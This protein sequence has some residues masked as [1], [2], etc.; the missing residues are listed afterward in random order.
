MSKRLVVP[1]FRTLREDDV[2]LEPGGGWLVEINGQSRLV[3][4]GIFS[5]WDAD[6]EFTLSRSV[7]LSKSAGAYLASG[8]GNAQVSLSLVVRV[9]T[10]RGRASEVVYCQPIDGAG[11]GLACPV[12]I[13]PDSAGLSENI[14]IEMSIVVARSNIPGDAFTPSIA[15]SRVWSD[16]WVAKLEGG[17]SRLPFEK[18]DFETA[19]PLQ[20]LSDSLFHVRVAEDPDLDVEQALTVWLNLRK[21]GFIQA[22]E[23]KDRHA[24]AMLW[25][26]ILR[27]A[28]IAGAVAG[29]DEVEHVVQGSIGAQWKRWTQS[30]FG[31]LSAKGILEM[32]DTDASRFE[33]IVQSWVNAWVFYGEGE[34]P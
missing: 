27:R 31:Q 22:I 34:S 13:Q 9:L 11:A 20:R 15:G 10:A 28:I 33:N 1:P 7:T 17:R 19:F 3:E 18:I 23:L 25:D 4:D 12:R 32:H 24:T 8:T 2:I 16:T 26:G 6:S 14:V 21:P 29:F 5:G 30:A